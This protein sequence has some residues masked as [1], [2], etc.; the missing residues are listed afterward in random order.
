MAV[1]SSPPRRTFRQVVVGLP[2]HNEQ[3]TIDAAIASILTSADLLDGIE[4]R[5]VIACDTCV[6]DTFERATW[7]VLNDPRVEVICGGW[8]SAGAARREA[9]CRGL[10]TVGS[11]EHTWVATTDADTVVPI[12]WLQ[13]QLDL[14]AEGWDGIAGIVELIDDEELTADVAA[15]FASSY[16]TDGATHE[17]VH[18][19]NLGCS[20]VGY[21]RAGGFAEIALAEDHAL[22]AALVASG[23]RCVSTTALRVGTS[24]RLQGRATGGFADALRRGVGELEPTGRA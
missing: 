24:A 8:R 11:P 10:A 7:W 17:H 22:W 13:V 2:A 20:A 14:A 12:D 23:A 9:I 1:T 5:I 19:A 6:D 18:G 16:R 3:A 4:V 15:H 21:L